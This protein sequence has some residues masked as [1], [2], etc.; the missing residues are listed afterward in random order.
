MNTYYVS[1][2][3][4]VG[5]GELYITSDKLS[6]EIIEQAKSKFAKESKLILKQENLRVINIIKMDN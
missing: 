5:Y 6:K 1:Y 4:Q 2:P 3:S